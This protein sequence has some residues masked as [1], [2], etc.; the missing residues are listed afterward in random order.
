MNQN[1]TYISQI[2]ADLDREISEVRNS[3]KLIFL[4]QLRKK[5]LVFLKIIFLNFPVM[6]FPTSSIEVSKRTPGWT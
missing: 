2:I 4:K 3:D 6:S 1:N 5:G